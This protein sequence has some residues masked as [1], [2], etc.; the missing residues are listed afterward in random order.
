LIWADSPIAVSWRHRVITDQGEN[1]LRDIA[2]EHDGIEWELIPDSKAPSGLLANL[3][4]ARATK[5]SVKRVDDHGIL[6]GAIIRIIKLPKQP[7]PFCR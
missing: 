1:R 6:S 7:A 5:S 3:Q 4:A 2:I